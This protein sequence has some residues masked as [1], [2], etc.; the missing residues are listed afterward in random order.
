[1]KRKTLVVLTAIVAAVVIPFS[2]FAAAS[3]SSS[4]K[5]E[6][7]APVELTEQQKADM[8][9]FSAKLAD[10]QKEYIAKMVSNGSI[11]QEQADKAIEKIDEMLESGKSFGLPGIT[12]MGGEGFGKGANRD[13]AGFLGGIRLSELTDEQKSS[14]SEASE[15]IASLQTEFIDEMVS[16]GL[17][18][19]EQGS[20]VLKRIEAASQDTDSSNKKGFGIRSPGG[21]NLLGREYIDASKLTDAQKELLTSFYTRLSDI[22]KELVNAMV[23]NGAITA[24]QGKTCIQNIDNMLKSIEEN[25]FT[26]LKDMGKGHI[27]GRRNNAPGRP[28]TDSSA[29]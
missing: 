28:N 4:G 20:A 12:G 2:V 18:T 10:L 8:E 7:A 9:E 25:G 22:Q 13:D 15:K 23:S 1:M 6:K 5:K 19:D 11:T 24:E 3:D 26:A 21:L 27:E 14:L 17:M 16:E 29:D